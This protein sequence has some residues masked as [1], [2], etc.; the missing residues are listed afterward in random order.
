M[1]VVFHELLHFFQPCQLPYLIKESIPAILN[2]PNF[3]LET[4]DA[5]L[6][7][8]ETNYYR[9]MVWDIYCKGKTYS[10]FLEDIK[11]KPYLPI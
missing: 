9:N 2:H 11:S 4:T 5:G 10:S 1:H 6:N 7:D 8:S 3:K